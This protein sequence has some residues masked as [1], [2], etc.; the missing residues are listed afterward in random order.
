ME[1]QADVDIEY[2]L[3]KDP[4][5]RL[6]ML[7]EDD[8]DFSEWSNDVFV[9]EAGARDKF[10]FGDVRGEGGRAGGATTP[11]V[12]APRSNESAIFAVAFIAVSLFQAGFNID[13]WF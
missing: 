2:N 1:P 12:A 4:K 10:A 5:P 9:S 8:P 6:V 13:L 3:A 11:E 7:T